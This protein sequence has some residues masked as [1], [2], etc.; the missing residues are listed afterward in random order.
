MKITKLLATFITLSLFLTLS[1][2]GNAQRKAD[3][4][5]QYEQNIE[6]I[7][8]SPLGHVIVKEKDKISCY[9][10]ETN[11]TEWEV[12]KKELAAT[13]VINQAENTLQALSSPD[14]LALFESGESIELIPGS[15]FVRVVLDN[16]DVIINSTDG[17][18]VFN[19]ATV[20]YR[21]VRSELILDESAFLFIAADGKM[22]NAVW[23]DLTEGRN[24]WMSP[25]ATVETMG[26]LLKSALSSAF[27]LKDNSTE[28]KLEVGKEAI[29]TSIGGYLYRLNKT[30]GELDW[31]SDFKIN[32]FFLSQ[33]EK[34][35]III[36]N[37]ASMLSSKQALNILNADNGTAIWKN[38]I[39][40]KYV[41]YLEDW[42]D[43]IL[44]AHSSGFNFFNY[45]DG[46]KVW[47]KDAQGNNIKRVIAI[48]NDYLY[49][50]GKEMNLIDRDGKNKWK[51]TIEI[52]DKDDDV[53][54]FLDKVENNRVFYL[55]DSYGNMVDYLSGKKI[56][57]KNIEFSRDKP[58]LYAQDEN[59]GAFLV[60]NDKKIYR[61]NPNTT[62]KPEPVAKLKAIKEDKTMAGI[63]L[64]DW[65]I[66]LTGQSDVI[67][68][69]FNGETRYHNTYKEPGGGKR[70]ALNALGKVASISAGTAAAV[71]G[72]EV[73]FSSRNERGEQVETGRA[74]LFGEKG[75]K[76]AQLAG[77]SADIINS[78]LLS[79][80]SNRFNALKQNSNY[81][82]VLAKNEKGGNPL[83]IKVKKE[84][85]SEVDK[86]EIDNNNPVYEVDGVTDNVFYVLKNELRVFSKN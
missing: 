84:D 81:A 67:G 43:R 60:Y 34:D 71:A 27:S 33:S 10:P 23:Y 63:E 50:T 25:L 24:K 68:V 3:V 13:S 55:T 40:T 26:T 18:V 66:C 36:K 37:S 78:T 58:L 9:N 20:G 75:Q 85:G 39:S 65:G 82:F 47:K 8:L 73:V 79:R 30:N 86:I 72:T 56:W 38:D 44:V 51:K 42:S 61:F 16:N 14:L 64:F 12:G 22:F 1:I 29:Y 70:K 7:L 6:N 17:K 69:T 41:S 31:K 49:I 11:Q 80:V 54:Y 52:S 21:I 59:T 74:N 15:P 28:D 57:K 53:V 4:V 46:G 76:Q 77:Q 5:V 2:S 19:S 35:I 48:D 62:D 32:K 83:L 45:S